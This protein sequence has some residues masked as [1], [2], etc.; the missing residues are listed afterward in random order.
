MRFKEGKGRDKDG[1]TSINSSPSVGPS[2]SVGRRLLSISAQAAGQAK[3]KRQEGSGQ[4]R[5]SKARNWTV[6]SAPST[7]PGEV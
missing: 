6:P 7:H 5:K 2:P 1:I 4:V 3:M